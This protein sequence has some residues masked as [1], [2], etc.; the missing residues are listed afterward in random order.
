ME[1][2]SK[3][4]SLFD[5]IGNNN[6]AN[7]VLEGIAKN[8]NKNVTGGLDTLESGLNKGQFEDTFKLMEKGEI[9]IDL[10]HVENYY[11]FN[12]SKLDRE[13]AQLSESFDL[14]TKIDVA[15]QDGILIVNGDSDNA[16]A[17][18]QYFDKDT[19]LT[20]LIQQTSKLSKFVE[21]GHARQ[22]AAEFK[23]ND[24]PEEQLVGFL[25]DAR[26]VVTQNN[27]F[28]FSESG[29]AYASK[30][31]TQYLIDKITNEKSS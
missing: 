21:W 10:N 25:K 3:S 6:Q 7:T 26:T 28:S 19:R 24:M 23:A 5:Y 13:V 14:K 27:Q 20:N 18:Q 9:D 8:Y 4:L 29:S 12:K 31:H 15:L 16:K 11:Q 17:L 22:Q 2:N 1:I 30:G